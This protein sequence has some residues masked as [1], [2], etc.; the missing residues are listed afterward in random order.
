MR[1]QKILIFSDCYIYGGSE[2]LMAFLLKNEIL[3]KNFIFLYAYR[4]HKSYE[5]GLEN[6]KLLDRKGNHPLLL[7]SNETLF[8]KINILK[9]NNL[10][11]KVIKFPFF[12]VEK[13]KFY[14][15]WNLLVLM[16]LLLK[17]KP[18]LVHI[19]NG[20]YPAAKSCNIFVVANYLTIKTKI[21]YQVNNQA[22]SCNSFL[23]RI[24]DKFIYKNVNLFIN[25]SHK[26]KQ[27]L[28]E[29]RN[30]NPN[31]IVLVDN[32]VPLP[33]VKKNK[34]EL[35]KELNIPLDSFLIV[36]VAFLSER[37]GQRYLIDALSDLFK[38]QLLSKEKVYCAFVGNG[39]QESFL[40]NYINELGLN[41]N[42]FLLGYRNN[43]EDF[44]SACNLFILPSIKDEDMPL[45]LLSA[46]GYG[47]P[48]IATDFAGISQVIETNVNGVLLPNNLGTFKET[49][50]NEIYRLYNEEF[51]RVKLGSNARETYANYSPATYGIKLKQIYE[52]T[53]AS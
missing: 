25:A 33:E 14:F 43:S 26:A 34:Q 16:Y 7:L 24:Y 37:K 11:K 53:Y 22:Q 18:T 3:N 19:N 50:A 44:I 47:K 20:G 10:V 9:V 36:E 42:I 17:T 5:I 51:L 31:K 46:L 41:S 28:V 15:L 13:I 2:K 45:V 52:Q 8:H 49:L 4:K 30:F 6:E 27:Q 23:E 40:K 48:I 32:C 29:K 1:K 38:N 39:E 21:I 12:L 35:F